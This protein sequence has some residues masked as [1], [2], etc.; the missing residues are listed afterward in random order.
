MM[1]QAK[2]QNWFDYHGKYVQSTISCTGIL[3]SVSEEWTL[4]KWAC[5]M[6]PTQ[7]ISYLASDSH[8]S[9]SKNKRSLS[10]AMRAQRSKELS[11]DLEIQGVWKERQEVERTIRTYLDDFPSKLSELLE[12][13]PFL[14][15][16]CFIIATVAFLHGPQ[17]SGKSRLL[18]TMIQD[19]DR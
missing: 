7:L 16:L 11:S 6:L 15:S 19:S 14:C 2:M 18:E 1:V 12:R 17:G 5:N 8:S 10:A 9:S 3:P 13:S 4:Y